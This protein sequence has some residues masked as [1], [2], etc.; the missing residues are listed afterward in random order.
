MTDS[1]KP[2][3]FFRADGD[4]VIGLGHIVRS[5]AMA[6]Y[7]KDHYKCILLTRCHIQSVLNEASSIFS[8][9]VSLP[10]IDY[11]LEARNFSSVTLK[12]S[13]FV[14]DG[15]FFDSSYQKILKS[16]GRDFFFIDDIHAFKYYARVIINQSGKI[17]PI[18]YEALPGT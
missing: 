15:Y 6:A 7:L 13:L 17:N 12:N 16:Q 2:S 9:I 18:D 10:V 8:E 1:I 11:Y 4:S 14:L 5:S 3:I